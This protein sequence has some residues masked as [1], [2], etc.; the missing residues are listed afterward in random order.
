[1]ILFNRGGSK[2]WGEGVE[3][4]A[5][6]TN[7]KRKRCIRKEVCEKSRNKI[8]EIEKTGGEDSLREFENGV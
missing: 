1:M 5:E 3:G 4:E 7:R 8:A 6:E 2:S